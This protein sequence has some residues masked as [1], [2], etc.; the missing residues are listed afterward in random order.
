MDGHHHV[1]SYP[2]DFINI[3]FS[4]FAVFFALFDFLGFPI[5]QFPTYVHN[6]FSFLFSLSLSISLSLSR[7]SQPR[8][9]STASSIPR[10][11]DPPRHPDPKGG[12]D[13]GSL[14]STNIQISTFVSSK[15]VDNHQQ[16]ISITIRD[17]DAL[18][19]LLSPPCSVESSASVAEVEGSQP[20]AIG[21]G[22]DIRDNLFKN[23]RG[24]CPRIVGLAD[25][26]DE[27]DSESIRS[28][29]V[30][31]NGTKMGAKDSGCS[32]VPHDADHDDARS[33]SGS[34]IEST[35]R[36]ITLERRGCE[37]AET[38]L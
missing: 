4:T 16:D 27:G 31:Y 28:N 9:G 29:R 1:Y 11:N 17:L 30:N 3:G 25:K 14:A 12:G 7:L 21:R 8:L 15:T 6:S 38:E 24:D 18:S 33:Q 22:S 37:A 2:I 23:G 10:A 20:T 13:P 32:S 26:R 35:A 5:S 36:F 19:H 34:M